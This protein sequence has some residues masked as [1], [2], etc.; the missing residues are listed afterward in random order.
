[1]TRNIKPRSAKRILSKKSNQPVFHG[2]AVI[3]NLL[4]V[5]F[6]NN[7]NLKD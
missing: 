3:C 4:E 6:I 5:H 1:M 2:Q 7:L